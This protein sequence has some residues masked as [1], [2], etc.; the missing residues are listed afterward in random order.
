VGLDVMKLRSGLFKS[1]PAVGVRN[2]ELISERSLWQLQ[3]ILK[4]VSGKDAG[5]RVKPIEA[6]FSVR[7]KPRPSGRVV[8]SNL[9][10]RWASSKT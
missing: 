3:E 4:V 10:L 5:L 9:Q 6:D 1:K 2:V 7:H 8:T